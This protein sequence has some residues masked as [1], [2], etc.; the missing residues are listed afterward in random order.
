MATV[1]SIEGVYPIDSRIVKENGKPKLDENGLIEVDRKFFA[2]KLREVM[3]IFLTDGVIT[4]RG[5]CLSVTQSGG[6]WSVGT[7][8]AVANGLYIPVDEPAEVIAQSEIGTGQYAYIVVAGRF[9]T[10]YRDGAIYPVVTTSPSYQP[11][12]DESTYELVLARIDWRGGFADYRLDNGMC[13][14][15][16][17][18]EEI[19][20]DSFMLELYT[21]VSQFNLN[22]GEVSSLPSGST[23]EVVVR[24]PTMAGGDVYIDFGIPRGAPGSPGQSAPG[25][26][27]QQDRPADPAE[28]V[29]WM[30]TDPSTRQ[31]EHIEAYEVTGT[32]PG[33]AYPGERYPGGTAAWAAYTINPALIAGSQI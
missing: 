2:G 5:D 24:K 10:D 8:S 29:I 13:G 16:A 33:E 7:G 20:T 4:K 32:Y 26:Y 1:T 19:D 15:V 6:V 11:V 23:P 18:L 31:I 17:P 28:G 12:R 3:S 27:I 14:A 25:L 21:A 9:E 22:V 30:G